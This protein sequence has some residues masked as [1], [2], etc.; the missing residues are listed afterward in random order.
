MSARPDLASVLAGLQAGDYREELAC[1]LADSADFG[2][3]DWLLICHLDEMAVSRL[4]RAFQVDQIARAP[5]SQVVQLPS[6]RS[7]LAAPWFM[8]NCGPACMYAILH[9]FLMSPAGQAYL[10]RV[11][12]S[13][14][15]R[16]KEFGWLH[17][18][19]HTLLYSEFGATWRGWLTWF[20]RLYK[21]LQGGL[22]LVPGLGR[23]VRP[24]LAGCFD[25]FGDFTDFMLGYM[26]MF[27]G[28]SC[29]SA[30]RVSFQATCRSCQ[31]TSTRVDNFGMLPSPLGRGNGSKCT[32]QAHADFAV[33]SAVMQQQAEEGAQALDQP[34]A[35]VGFLCDNCQQTSVVGRGYLDEAPDLLCL[36]NR[37]GEDQYDGY[38]DGHVVT[39]TDLA[40]DTRDG[41]VRYQPLAFVYYPRGHYT[42][43]INYRGRFW[44]VDPIHANF[45]P[46]SECMHREDHWFGLKN[47][48]RQ[49]HFRPSDPTTYDRV[50][51]R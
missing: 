6:D 11:R 10:R 43:D 27:A 32:D 47:R 7:L 17:M 15:A 38:R 50:V 26:A 49:Q 12:E 46:P 36:V 35:V 48:M 42:V 2:K 45:C 33:G 30:V 21:F 3:Y 34:A 20:T 25:K 28:T 8:N 18:R 31:H 4:V 44:H 1:A 40:I 41:P 39:T 13:Q 5:P 23:A 51:P 14:A 24:E 16:D 9:M 37:A 29:E 22:L 19:Y